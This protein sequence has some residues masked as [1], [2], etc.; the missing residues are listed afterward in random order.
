MYE[1]V[2]SPPLRTSPKGVCCGM[3]G[4]YLSTPGDRYNVSALVKAGLVIIS[5]LLVYMLSE[6]RCTFFNFYMA[7]SNT[8]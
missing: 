2:L 3:R 6:Q 5:F 8:I 7:S 4:A 1:G